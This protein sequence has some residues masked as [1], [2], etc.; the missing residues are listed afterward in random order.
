MNIW[1]LVVYKFWLPQIWII[2]V[3]A[4]KKMKW[5]IFECLNAKTTYEFRSVQEED[6]FHLQ[7]IK[8]TFDKVEY[9]YLTNKKMVEI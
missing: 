4:I 3:N 8:Y 1:Q 2:V 5:T 9:F 6:F 7:F